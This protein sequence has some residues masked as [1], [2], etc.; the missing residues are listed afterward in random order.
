MLLSKTVLALWALTAM[1]VQGDD[2]A[3]TFLQEAESACRQGEFSEY[4]FYMAGSREASHFAAPQVRVTREGRT[5][6]VPRSTWRGLSIAT[7]DW[8][9]IASD[10]DADAP[11][12]LDV[13]MRE[14]RP[15]TWRVDW[16][17]ARYD[18]TGEGDSLGNVVETYGPLGH[19]LFARAG[20]CWQITDDVVE[21]EVARWR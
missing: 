17:R 4:L 6:N 3:R 15:G 19:Y 16:V 9:Y 2:G 10:G 7:I 13:Q 18:R 5:R 20:D 14:L 8:Y 12:Y 11:D 21:A 1:T